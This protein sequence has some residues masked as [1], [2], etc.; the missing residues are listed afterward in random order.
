MSVTQIEVN[1]YSTSMWWTFKKLNIAQKELIMSIGFLGAGTQI[2]P[3]FW[4][5]LYTDAVDYTA[6]VPV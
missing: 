2:D 3:R 1:I 6:S 5:V 4:T